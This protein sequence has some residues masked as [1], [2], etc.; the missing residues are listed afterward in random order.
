MNGVTV[1]KGAVL[2]RCLV[3]ENTKIPDGMK[4]GKK[5]SKEILLVTNKLVAE[6]GGKKRGK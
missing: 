2:N 4:I 6:L 1:G 3:A 5:D